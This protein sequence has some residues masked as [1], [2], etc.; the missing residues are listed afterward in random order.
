MH[1]GRSRDAW[2][3]SL[4]EWK[5]QVILSGHTHRSRWLPPTKVHPYGQL[6]GG[7]PKLHQA[8]WTEGRADG[9]RLHLK[10]NNLEGDTLHDIQ[11]RPLV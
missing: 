1:S 8:T 3:E 2:H 9:S 5:T 4:V 10:V 11:I 7:G 6:T